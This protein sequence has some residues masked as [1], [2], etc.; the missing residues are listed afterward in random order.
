MSS[1]MVIRILSIS[2]ALVLLGMVAPCLTNASVSAVSEVDLG[3]VL[4]NSS[5]P[6]STTFVIQNQNEDADS[7][8]VLLSI[9][10]ES[11]LEGEGACGFSYDETLNGTMLWPGDTVTMTIEYAPSEPGVCSDTLL[12]FYYDHNYNFCEYPVP[13][14][15]TGE[16][17]DKVAPSTVMIDGQD[18]EVENRLYKDDRYIS[19]WLDD[20]AASARNHGEYVR[21]VAL[22][23]KN[24]KKTK[25]LNEEEKGAIMKAAAHANIPPRKSSIEDLSYDGTPVTELIKECKE[26]AKNNKQYMR[27]VSDLMKEMKKKGEIETRKDKHLIRRYAARLRF[28]GKPHK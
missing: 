1:K 10:L 18:T 11:E 15:L 19:E 16:G 7:W 23:T 26:E 20:C 27:C 5:T 25:L 12:V 8:I 3:Q 24:M 22:L 21:C 28:H 2:L 6:A 14:V 4:I 17:I 13:V 9:G